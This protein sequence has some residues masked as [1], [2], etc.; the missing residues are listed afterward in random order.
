MSFLKKIL[1][2]SAGS[3]LKQLLSLGSVFFF[4]ACQ[5]Q[6][7]QRVSLG[8]TA[9]VDGISL[10]RSMRVIDPKLML[11]NKNTSVLEE[12]DESLE[13]RKPL[14]QLKDSL[15]IGLDASFF[16]ERLLFGGTILELSEHQNPLL[17]MMKLASVDPLNLRAKINQAE[18]RIDLLGCIQN[19]DENS[20]EIE[21]FS[22]AIKEIPNDSKIYLD[23]SEIAQ[24]LN[25]V[26]MLDPYGQAVP[27]LTEES[28]A[29]SVELDKNFLVFDILTK[30]KTPLAGVEPKRLTVKSRWFLSLDSENTYFQSQVN[31]DGVGFLVSPRS[32]DQKIKK[33]PL[34]NS[35]GEQKLTHYYIKNVPL[36]YRNAIEG[37]FKEW[38]ELFYAELGQEIFSYE[39]L[40]EEDANAQFIV[41]GDPRYNVVEWELSN[42]APY[43]GYG[44]SLTNSRTGEALSASVII[45]GENIVSTIKNWYQ[46]NQEGPEFPM[47]TQLNSSAASQIAKLIQAESSLMS[48]SIG[49]ALNFNI[50][51]LK[52]ELSDIASSPLAFDEIPKVSVEE[53]LEGYIREVVAHELGHNLGLRHN[54]KGSLHAHDHK[55]PTLKKN[56][57]NSVMDYLVRSEGYLNQVSDYDK[58]AILYG[59][60]NIEPE[61][62]D[63]F[64]TD[65]DVATLDVDGRNGL[66]YISG[67]PECSR[68]DS[69]SDPFS[70]F[71]SQIHHVSEKLSSFDDEQESLDVDI[72][73]ARSAL[74]KALMGALH[75]A[76]LAEKT[77]DQW[78]NF[79]EVDGRPERNDLAIKEYVQLEVVKAVCNEALITSVLNKKNSALK[80]KALKNL[81][82]FQN[83]S[84][85]RMQFLGLVSTSVCPE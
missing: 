45:Q 58:M 9:Q 49:K 39:F 24:E 12:G 62:K 57:S 18:K 59:Y 63:L 10:G 43:D 13:N 78:T 48:L 47:M 80:L 35:I 83:F 20:K 44:P 22:L 54:F 77:K 53:Y 3:Y 56:V 79:F 74:T 29:V 61:R 73:G 6:V 14:E 70:Y 31:T 65:D 19:C 52:S 60:G 84:L 41:A 38:N 30:L 75:Y 76:L 34:L 1:L 82:D 15:H 26:R 42:L 33:L 69:S 17:G 67:N 8:Q 25:L 55:D 5:S 37:A 7:P 64:C 50:S 85:M 21:L 32:K 4:L 11:E 66:I 16:Q 28:Q 36:E 23:F 72:R 27:Y 46:N 2:Q 40:E 71:I 68:T 51:S 81:K